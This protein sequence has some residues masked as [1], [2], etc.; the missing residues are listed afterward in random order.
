MFFFFFVVIDIVFNASPPPP[1]PFMFHGIYQ[2][3][4]SD[5]DPDAAFHFKADP[6]PPFFHFNADPKHDP[7]LHQ[8]KGILRL[9]VYRPSWIP[10]PSVALFLGI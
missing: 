9:L 3:F 5:L 8:N 7:G 6:D 1:M 4:T 2:D 10:H